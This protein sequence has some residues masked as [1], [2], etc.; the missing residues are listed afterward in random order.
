MET[1]GFFNLQRQ[2]KTSP[3]MTTIMSATK[4]KNPAPGPMISTPA[5]T[6]K[7]A[8]PPDLLFSADDSVSSVEAHQAELKDLFCDMVQ[9]LSDIEYDKKFKAA[10]IMTQRV[11]QA[12]IVPD[13]AHPVSLFMNLTKKL[14]SQ[15]NSYRKL[16]HL[17]SSSRN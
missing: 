8:T 17:A 6:D 4:T 2:R 15:R 16:R 5:Y 7:N 11:M 1:K 12:L 13:A 3:E 9:Q 10:E 14:P